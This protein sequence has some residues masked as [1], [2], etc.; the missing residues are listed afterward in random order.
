MGQVVHRQRELKALGRP[1]RLP[2]AA[3]LQ[4]SIEHQAVERLRRLQQSFCAAL[5]AG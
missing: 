2:I 1:A 3:V 5:D 4:T